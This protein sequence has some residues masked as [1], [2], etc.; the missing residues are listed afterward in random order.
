MAQTKMFRAVFFTFSLDS[1]NERLQQ[2]LGVFTA[3]TAVGDSDIS[4]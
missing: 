2:D 1:E 4:A 3:T